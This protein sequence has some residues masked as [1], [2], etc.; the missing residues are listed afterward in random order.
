MI[1]AIAAPVARSAGKAA[2]KPVDGRPACKGSAA[3]CCSPRPVGSVLSG[4]SGL[5]CWGCCAAVV[6][7]VGVAAV[8][9][10]PADDVVL[11]A[12]AEEGWF[13]TVIVRLFFI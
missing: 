4:W 10:L 7:L 9:E 2:A 3:G 1:A 12:G 13:V 8:P 6:F 5:F 11:F